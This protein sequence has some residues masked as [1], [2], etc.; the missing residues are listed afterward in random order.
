MSHVN[1]HRKLRALAQKPAR[2]IAQNVVVSILLTMVSR[3]LSGRKSWLYPLTM[4]P[5]LQIR[6]CTEDNSK[7]IFLISHGK[8]ML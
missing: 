5:K 2:M 1:K 3:R 4:S 8:H 6:G 7:T